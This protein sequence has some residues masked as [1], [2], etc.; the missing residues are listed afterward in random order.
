MNRWRV[1]FLFSFLIHNASLM[2]NTFYTKGVLGIMLSLRKL[3]LFSLGIKK[4]KKSTRELF[5]FDANIILNVWNV[6][7]TLILEH[8]TYTPLE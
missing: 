4:E 7:C 1:L 8:E 3:E 2:N 6:L 5:Y